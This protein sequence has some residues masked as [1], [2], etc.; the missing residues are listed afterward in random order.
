MW[1]LSSWSHPLLISRWRKGEMMVF[2]MCTIRHY[3]RRT[4][5]QAGIVIFV[6]LARSIF[7]HWLWK[8]INHSCRSYSHI[9]CGRSST[10]P[11]GLQQIKTIFTLLIPYE[12]SIAST[13]VFKNN[14]QSI[15]FCVR[16]L[17]SPRL[18]SL[19]TWRMSQVLG[20]LSVG[21]LMATQRVV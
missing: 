18:L 14:L 17:Q 21:S 20:Y 15:R 1:D 13:S 19:P 11:A 12:I 3:L 16:I 6:L 2:L 5:S 8:V 9:G 10:I 7:S 4:P